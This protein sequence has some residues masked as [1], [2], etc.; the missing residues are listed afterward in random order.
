MPV[1]SLLFLSL[2]L[3]LVACPTTGDDDDASNDDDAVADPCEGY[4]APSEF[5]DMNDEEKRD[6]MTCV[7]VPEMAPRFQE[8]DADEYANFGCDTCHGDDRVER[9]HE[10]PN[11]DLYRLP[12]SGFPFSDDPD[13][14]VAVY[15]DFMETEVSG[16]M[17]D[18]LGRSSE[19]GDP[20]FFGCYGCHEQP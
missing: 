19:F 4:E 15:G 20:D 10:M 2:S 18:L 17:A 8:F 16:N 5:D 3:F 11:P 14:E 12:L 7:V 9:E 6:Y 13:P 1:R